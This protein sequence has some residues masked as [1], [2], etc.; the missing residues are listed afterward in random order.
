MVYKGDLQHNYAD[1][2]RDAVAVKTLKGIPSN[3]GKFKTEENLSIIVGFV[4]RA[5]VRELLMECAK[6][7]KFDHPNVLKLIGV[8]LDGGPA[9]YIVMPFMANGSL[10]SYLKKQRDNLIVD[11]EPTTYFDIVSVSEFI[12]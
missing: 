12:R 11:P 6:M 1:N 2:V 8:C 7:Q 9:P 5:R 10:L 4:Q 3:Y